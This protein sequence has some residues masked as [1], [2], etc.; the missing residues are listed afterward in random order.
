[1][2]LHHKTN[3]LLVN[4]SLPWGE[5]MRGGRKVKKKGWE[6]REGWVG[7]LEMGLGGGYDGWVKILETST[8][9]YEL[10]TDMLCHA[11]V[12]AAMWLVVAF[13]GDGYTKKIKVYIWDTR[14]KKK[15]QLS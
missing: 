4:V 14:R 12:R 9:E 10:C 6:R 11:L 3:S 5:G 13:N 15:I 7:W 8:I 2:Q 1:M